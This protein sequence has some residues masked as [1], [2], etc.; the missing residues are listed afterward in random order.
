MLYSKL[1]IVYFPLCVPVF[2][3]FWPG[4]VYLKV[5][6]IIL[7]KKKKKKSYRSTDRYTYVI[8]AHIIFHGLFV[9]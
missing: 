1:F 6:S 8:K 9:Y 7:W 2:A 3:V 5:S 4:S